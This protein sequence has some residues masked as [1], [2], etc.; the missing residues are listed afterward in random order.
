MGR[1]GTAGMLNPERA[2]SVRLG[3]GL[4]G[5]GSLANLR[6]GLGG[7]L[8]DGARREPI[9]GSG[10]VVCGQGSSGLWA[11]GSAGLGTPVAGGAAGRWCERFE[12]LERGEEVTGPGPGVL[13]V[14][15]R[16]AARERE[17]S[18]GGEQPVTQPL[19]L[20]FRELAVK[21]ERLGPD[22]QVVREHHDLQPHFVE[23]ERFERELGQAS[24]LVVA[25][26]VLDVRVL[27]V[28][29]LQHRDVR[30]GLVGEDRLEAVAVM[31]G[32]R[33]L[34]AGVRT[35]APDDQP[36]PLRPAG[37]IDRVGDLT[38]LAVLARRAVLVKRWDPG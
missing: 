18:R 25:D 10:R 34:R 2:V 14:Q 23:R 12:L 37:Q 31:V 22:D 6:A 24:V 17:P 16:P 35:L 32:E 1:R 8:P 15:L 30:V 26:P 33:Q 28:T 3:P 5:R 29:A 13:E 36:G 20:G 27:A 4:S 38:D 19:G 11:R 9:W 21:A 7:V